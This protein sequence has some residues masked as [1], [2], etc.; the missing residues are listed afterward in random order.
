MGRSSL[1]MAAPFLVA[2]LTSNDNRVR[3]FA[4]APRT[5]ANATSESAVGGMEAP[6]VKTRDDGCPFFG[7]PLFPADVHYNTDAV[8]AILRRIRD[9]PAEE[10]DEDVLKGDPQSKGWNRR[11]AVSLTLIGYKGGPVIQQINQDRA[12]V[13]SP[14]MGSPA[15]LPVSKDNAN[16]IYS[17]LSSYSSSQENGSKETPQNERILL[18]VF[19]GHGSRGELVSEYTVQN[20]PAT[21]ATKLDA[22]PQSGEEQRKEATI[23]ALHDT[24]VEMDQNA[25]AHPSGGCTASAILIQESSI[26]IANAGDSRSFVVAYRPSTRQVQILYISR[27]DKPDLPDERARVEA[28]GGQVYIPKRGTSRVVYQDPLTGTPSGLAMSRSIGDW[29]AAKLGV[30]PDPIVDVLEVPDLV[31]TV[32][33]NEMEQC[34]IVDENGE[35]D[36]SRCDDQSAAKMVDDVYIFGVAATDGMMDYL[37]P[38]DIAKVLASSLFDAGASHPVTACE[39]LIFSAA[40]SWQQDKQGRYRDDIAISVSVLRKPPLQPQ[41]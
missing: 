16:S 25:P 21:L 26:Y 37:S 29:A 12:I 40:N 22:L 1:A 23:R 7:C 20:L 5:S 15:E 8:K 11:D 34:F 10:V 13:V 41:E 6:E 18:A 2:F 14:F 4:D 33:K 36:R 32:L 38:E 19:D 35:V 3:T 30:I 17:M 28:M 27:E 31:Q 24:F 9:I 39:L